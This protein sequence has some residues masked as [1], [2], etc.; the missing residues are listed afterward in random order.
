MN[1][2]PESTRTED[3]Q[4]VL[5]IDVRNHAGVMSHLVGL[6]SRRACNVESIVCFPLGDGYTS[7]IWLLVPRKPRLTQMIKHAAN[8]ED[9]LAVRR[10]DE[11]Y[12][13]FERLKALFPEQSARTAEAIPDR[14]RR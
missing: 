9:V 12:S 3:Q 6:F 1:T 13:S 10:R 11:R 4:A 5:E 8:L 2:G 14:R 7:R